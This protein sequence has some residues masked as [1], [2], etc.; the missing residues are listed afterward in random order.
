MIIEAPIGH[1]LQQLLHE[2]LF[3]I[4]EKLIAEIESRYSLDRVWH[5]GGKKWAY[6]VKFRKG[7]KTICSLFLKEEALGFMVIFGK[8]EQARFEGRRSDFSPAVTEGYDATKTYHDGK[9]LLFDAQESLFADFM[10]L[11]LIKRKP[12]RNFASQ[13]FRPE[14]Q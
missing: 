6:E 7:S 11:L 13:D 9:W 8:P 14:F 1:D 10:E 4:F 12:D 3:A 5:S 2:P